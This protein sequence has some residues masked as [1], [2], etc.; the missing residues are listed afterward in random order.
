[1]QIEEGCSTKKRNDEATYNPS[2][3]QNEKQ[4]INSAAGFLNEITKSRFFF[5]IFV[6]YLVLVHTWY[7]FYGSTYTPLWSRN[8]AR[9]GA[10]G[11]L[12]SVLVHAY[13]LR[14]P[15]TSNIC[16]VVSY[17]MYSYPYE[18]QSSAWYI[19]GV[20]YLW[21]TCCG[22]FNFSQKGRHT[23]TDERYIRSRR[24]RAVLL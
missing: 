19:I 16:F 8:S 21:R 3:D 1:M 9:G 13:I 6:F 14:T 22:K 11:K 10:S 24:V 17:H 18:K 4:T 5:F 23:C 2:Q 15:V 12:F 20:S 7:T